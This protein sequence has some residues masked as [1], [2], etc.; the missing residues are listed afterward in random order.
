MDITIHLTEKRKNFRISEPLFSF[1]SFLTILR[2]SRVTHFCF[3]CRSDYPA[4]FKAK[5]L[6]DFN[7]IIFV[8]FVLTVLSSRKVTILRFSCCS[9]F[10]VTFKNEKIFSMAYNVPGICASAGLLARP[11]HLTPKIINIFDAPKPTPRK[12]VCR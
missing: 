5:K 2:S 11:C 1:F 10:S 4:T 12:R 3:S 9:Y 6:F 8:F 7:E